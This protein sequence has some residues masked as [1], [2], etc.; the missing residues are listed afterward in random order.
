MTQIFMIL[1]GGL[2]VNNFVMTRFLGICPFLGV[3]TKLETAAGM[4]IAVIF[5]MTLASI[6]TYLLNLL[7]IRFGLEYMQTL[8]FI[9]VI[10][11]LVQFVEMALKSYVPTLYNALGVYLPLITTN[12]AVLG[13]T[14]LNIT[15]SYNLIQSAVN[16]FAGGAG[17]MLAI[18]IFAGIRERFEV[19]DFP[20]WMKGFPGALITA[21]LMSV[22][23]MG[24]AGL[25][26]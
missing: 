13:V 25:L 11:A 6:I 3:S 2:L 8:V 19:S 9:V 23:F 4:G 12:C 5:V 10:A 7:L 17:F 16:G 21:S 1:V 15:E 14:L 26:R 18:C 22:S 20:E 24:F